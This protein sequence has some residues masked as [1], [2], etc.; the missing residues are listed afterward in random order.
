M[1]NAVSL[2]VEHGAET[3]HARLAR[4]AYRAGVERLAHVSGI[5][6]DAASG[7]LYI[8]NR[9]EG[10]LAAQAAFALDRCEKMKR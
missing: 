8:R 3:F 2:Y 6:A 1:V 7:S 4:Q 9:G 5:G 10:E